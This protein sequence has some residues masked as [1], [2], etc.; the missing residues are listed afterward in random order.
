MATYRQK[1]A[2]QGIVIDK[3]T[4]RQALTDAGYSQGIADNPQ[5]VTQSQGF[6]KLLDDMGLSDDDVATRHTQL[7][8]SS[9]EQIAMKAV[10][11]AYKVKGKYNQVSA[12]TQFNA[13][14]LIQITPPTTGNDVDVDVDK[15][16]PTYNR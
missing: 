4:A 2:L 13:P 14:V 8:K 10:D 9:N 5:M 12:K 15:D 6:L 3:K 7:M 1:K 16:N 11:T